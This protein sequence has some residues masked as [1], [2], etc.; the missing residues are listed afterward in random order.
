MLKGGLQK[1]IT[2]TPASSIARM[3]TTR[4]GKL[5]STAGVENWAVASLAEALEVAEGR[6]AA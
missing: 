5:A 6:K 3:S 4:F 1:F 2:V